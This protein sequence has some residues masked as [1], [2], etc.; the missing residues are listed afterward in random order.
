MKM[1]M[2]DFDL[3]LTYDQEKE[4]LWISTE[5]G[6]GAKYTVANPKQLASAMQE[7]VEIYCMEAG[8]ED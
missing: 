3:F 1:V 7:Y 8:N 6:S 4:L 5:Y 2:S